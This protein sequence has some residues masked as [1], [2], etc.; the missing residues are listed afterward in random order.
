[1]DEGDSKAANLPDGVRL[2][3]FTKTRGRLTPTITDERKFL[4]WVQDRYPDEI[5]QTIRPAFRTKILDTAK[6]HGEAVDLS[7]GE[8]VPGI[9][10]RHGDPYISFRSEPGYQEVVAERWHEIVGPRLLDGEL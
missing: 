9:E 5:E 7:T 1:L 3:K 2:G 10:L 4:Q 8:V 6:K